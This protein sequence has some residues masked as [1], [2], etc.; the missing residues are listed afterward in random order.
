MKHRGFHMTITTGLDD[1]HEPSVLGGVS[2]E[3]DLR[4]VKA[5]LLY[6]DDVTLY[7]PAASMLLSI[8]N[9]DAYRAKEKIDLLTASLPYI[10]PDGKEAASLRQ[11]LETYRHLKKQR[12]TTSEERRFIQGIEQASQ[13]DQMCSVSGK[14]ARDSQVAMLVRAIKSGRL[15]V[16]DFLKAKGQSR[17][18]TAARLI[19]QAAIDATARQ[20]Q[21]WSD[22]IIEDYVL[23]MSKAISSGQTFPLFDTQAANLARQGVREGMFTVSDTG[24]NRGRHS[25][26]A[27]DLLERLPL[28]EQASVDEIL[29]IRRELAKPLVR[30]RKAVTTFSGTIKAAAWDDDFLTEADAIFYRD[31][32]PVVQEIA[33][34][35]ESNRYLLQ[36]LR[37]IGLPAGALT[38]V[39]S[40]IA[41]LP[42]I[43]AQAI[44]NPAAAQ[45][46]NPAVA[47]AVAGA[48]GSAVFSTVWEKWDKGQNIEQQEL[49][50]YYRARK[51]LS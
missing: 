27:A 16:H 39:I 31:V 49:Y 46:V 12:Y 36:L 2:L 24:M 38:A 3:H 1:A 48:V 34:M 30:F 4:L 35:V 19:G 37:K 21:G 29:D 22:A 14:I 26:L 20:A 5:A 10:M 51:K 25:G 9:L 45:V 42:E 13:W 8:G 23:R 32:D 11:G 44:N 28:F 47:T 33:E 41:D 18:E 40:R 43:V 50:F 17:A 7:S 15:H 6:A